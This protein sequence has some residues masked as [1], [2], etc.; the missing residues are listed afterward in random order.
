MTDARVGGSMVNF[1]V[2]DLPFQLAAMVAVVTTPT[3]F[4][5]IVKVPV[6]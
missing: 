6:D 2:T 4:V 1:E 3:G 5:L